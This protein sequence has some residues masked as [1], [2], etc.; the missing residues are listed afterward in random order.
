MQ[1]LQ[2]FFKTLQTL[3]TLPG[4]HKEYDFFSRVAFQ[5]RKTSTAHLSLY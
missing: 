4:W 5:F 2:P 1:V 3:N